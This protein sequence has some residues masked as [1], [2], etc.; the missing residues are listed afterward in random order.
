MAVA[1]DGKPALLM[2]L[3][4]ARRNELAPGE[5]F[6]SVMDVRLL[7]VVG[8]KTLPVLRDGQPLWHAPRQVPDYLERLGGNTGYII[9]PEETMAD[10]FALLVTRSAARNPALLG[11]IEAVLTGR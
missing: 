2:P 3:L 11:R 9:H 8:D 10:N 1:I 6:F 5:T 4:L 7:E